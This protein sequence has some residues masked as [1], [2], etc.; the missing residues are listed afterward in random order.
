MYRWG[1]NGEFYD[2]WSSWLKALARL[3]QPATLGSIQ[4][5]TVCKKSVYFNLAPF[6]SLGFHV[7]RYRQAKPVG[8]RSGRCPPPSV[9]K[10]H[11]ADRSS[12]HLWNWVDLPRRFERW[13]QSNV[14][15]H[16]FKI[17]GFPCRQPLGIPVLKPWKRSK[18]WGK[19]PLPL[20]EGNGP[21]RH[22]LR[23][24]ISQ[25]HNVKG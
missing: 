3:A 19:R 1:R 21:E 12:V 20:S 24:T 15:N 2:C 17:R 23:T 6:P 7:H 8:G 13:P 25:C 11:S 14:I 9:L 22:A 16:Y 18:I 5:F 4:V 10:G